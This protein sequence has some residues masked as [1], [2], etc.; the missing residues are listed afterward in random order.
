MIGAQP[1]SAHETYKVRE[2][3]TLSHVAVRTGV[4]VSVLAQANGLADANHV[5]S[6][7][8]LV[9]PS[10]HVRSGRT[11]VIPSGAP[12]AA[13]APSTVAY[14][15]QAGDT[16][17]E[18]A[19]AA[20]VSTRELAE[21]NGLSDRHA[22]RVGQTLELPAT[23]GLVVQ[24]S[25]NY[26][27]LPHRLVVQPSANY[28]GLPQRLVNNPE[29]LALIPHFETWA[30]AN[31]IPVDLLMAIAWQE[32]GWNNAALSH[33][34]ARGV[35]QL[36]PQTEVWVATGLIGRPELSAVNPEDNIRISARY[37]RW[38]L[39]RMGGDERRAIAGYYQ[40]PTSVANG[41]LYSSTELYIRNVLVH[42]QFFTSN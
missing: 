41:P 42:R 2:R 33:K 9:I 31:N 36:M 21:R 7:R 5:R 27:R 19:L 10:G 6:G 16:L 18:I 30:A 32:S 12:S 1:V 39:D 14:T 3:E 40:G 35:G 20:G 38:L 26:P 34:G 25:A 13:V 15:V 4:S 24:P 37:V 11:L 17:S 28:P 29:R 22:I 8:T 23:P